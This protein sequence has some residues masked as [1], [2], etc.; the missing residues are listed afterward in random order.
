MEND[1]QPLYTDLTKWINGLGYDEMYSE[2]I[3]VTHIASTGQPD[4]FYQ[5]IQESEQYLFEEIINAENRC[6]QRLQRHEYAAGLVSIVSFPL[7]L[8]MGI[9]IGLF[10]L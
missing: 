8:F 6:I 5:L 1:Q 9:L 7:V 4:N 3:D 10:V 2:K